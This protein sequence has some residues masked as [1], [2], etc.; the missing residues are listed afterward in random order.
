LGRLSIVIKDLL[1]KEIRGVIIVLVGE[2][3]IV[4]GVVNNSKIGKPRGVYIIL[5]SEYSVLEKDEI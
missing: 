5:R 3:N 1:E 2:M 4:A